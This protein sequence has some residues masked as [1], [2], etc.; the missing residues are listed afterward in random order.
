MIRAIYNLPNIRHTFFIVS[1]HSWILR[2]RLRTLGNTIQIQEIEEILLSKDNRKPISHQEWTTKIILENDF[3]VSLSHSI[4]K[5]I[6]LPIQPFFDAFDL[7][8]VYS[9]TLSPYQTPS[10]QSVKS[11]APIEDKDVV[12]VFI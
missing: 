9:E 3:L 1:V 11:V 10:C 4:S 2:N 8:T 6:K 5:R 12:Q 7:L